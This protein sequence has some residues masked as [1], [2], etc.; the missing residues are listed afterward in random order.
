MKVWI[1]DQGAARAR[2]VEL[3]RDFGT[4]VEVSNGLQGNESVI[5]NPGE[6]LAEGVRVSIAQP[7]AVAGAGKGAAATE[8]AQAAR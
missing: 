2:K 5:T 7:P 8:P 6:R 1:V 4:E 3:G